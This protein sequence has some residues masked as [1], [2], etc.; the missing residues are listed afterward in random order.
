[1]VAVKFHY[2]ETVYKHTSLYR[3]LKYVVF[4]GKEVRNTE[5]RYTEVCYIK[6]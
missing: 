2:I 1:M 4:Y 6:V 5:F 3:V